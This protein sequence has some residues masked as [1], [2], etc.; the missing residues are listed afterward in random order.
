MLIHYMYA[1]MRRSANAYN[2]CVSAR[3]QTRTES[4]V[5]YL[6]LFLKT[7]LC[8]ILSTLVKGVIVKMYYDPTPNVTVPIRELT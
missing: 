2:P 8:V 4:L 5:D 6:Y 3:Q 1:S 7:L